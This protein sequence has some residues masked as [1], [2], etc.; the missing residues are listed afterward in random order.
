M[1][2]LFDPSALPSEART[3]VERALRLR[4]RHEEAIE[5][6]EAHLA[7]GGA[8]TADVL[9][10]LAL[11][12]YEDAAEVVLSRI[13]AA[14]AEAIRLIDEALRTAAVSRV[15][16]LR[17]L[18]ALCVRSQQAEQERERGLWLRA[19]SRSGGRATEWA[20]LAHRMQQRGEDE[21]ASRRCLGEALR[22]AD[23]C[24]PPSLDEALTA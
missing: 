17:Q 12:V 5:A 14:S 24:E 6:L 18:R 7:H 3:L 10:A 9:A 15:E 20:E 1:G 21:Q 13:E 8:R 2:A 22:R 11:C 23:L 19:S 16:P 4:D